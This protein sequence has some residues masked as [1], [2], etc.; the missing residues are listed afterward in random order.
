MFT[1]YTI[2]RETIDLFTNKSIRIKLEKKQ[3]ILKSH[4]LGKICLTGF[5]SSSVSSSLHSGLGQVGLGL[6]RK[7]IIYLRTTATLL[8]VK[9]LFSTSLAQPM[10][11]TR[12]D[13]IT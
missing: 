6:E 13:S 12:L 2:D 3:I 10:T 8:L 5:P 11:T 9:H 4:D 7:S 1:I